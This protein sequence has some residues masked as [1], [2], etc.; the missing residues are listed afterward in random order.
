M[1][2]VRRRTL[3]VLPQ[4]T[5]SLDEFSTARFYEL[6]D[7]LFNIP[8]SGDILDA[9]LLEFLQLATSSDRFLDM[10]RA[11]PEHQAQNAVEMLQQVSPYFRLHPKRI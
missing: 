5:V 8:L 1:M 6:K 9:E 3:T 2:S 11:L 7:L 4:P 10:T